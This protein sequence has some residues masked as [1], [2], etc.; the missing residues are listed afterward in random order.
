MCNFIIYNPQIK[1]N[2]QGDHI[3]EHENVDGLV[4]LAEVR[5]AYCISVLENGR[6][7]TILES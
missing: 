2:C 6:E 3:K 5:Y 4:L 1:T 7:E